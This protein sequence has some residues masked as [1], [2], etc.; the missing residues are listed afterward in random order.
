MKLFSLILVSLYILVGCAARKS[1]ICHERIHDTSL[2]KRTTSTQCQN[3]TSQGDGNLCLPTQVLIFAAINKLDPNFEFGHTTILG[4]GGNFCGLI[5][6]DVPELVSI[7]GA[8]AELNVFH[9]S[10]PITRSQ[11]CHCIRNMDLR[12]PYNP[13]ADVLE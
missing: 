7:P 4:L 12:L 5:S 11:R 2:D 1:N 8:T 13:Y 6:Y 9:Y 3:I 10:F